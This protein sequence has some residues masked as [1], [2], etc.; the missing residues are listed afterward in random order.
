MKCIR[1]LNLKV[2]S[3][4]I[5]A[6]VSSCQPDKPIVNSPNLDLSDHTLIKNWYS[7]SLELGPK[8]NGFEEPIMARSLA[9]YS[10]L[11]HESV[12]RGIPDLKSLKGS[13]GA[14]NFNFPQP[15]L[16][17]EYNWTTVANE[18]SKVY[19]ENIYGSGTNAKQRIQ[20]I[21]QNIFN[22]F[23]KGLDSV[24]LANSK[25]YGRELAFAVLNYAAED[26]QSEAYLDVFTNSY[27]IPTG[28][29]KW[30]PTTP[31][32]S[33]RP[34]LP[35]WGKVRPIL[36]Q[37]VDVILL[38]K[39]LNYS[40]S[41]S[42]IMY[43][44]AVEIYNMA[45]AMTEQEK[46]AAAYF[47]RDMGAMSQALYH[48]YLLAIQLMAE[49]QLDFPKSLEL[50][51][52]LSFA[53]HDGNIACYKYIYTNNLLR[54]STYIRQN[55]NRIY[56]PEYKSLP[57]PEGISDK[58]VC[59]SIGAE[60]LSNFFGY[61]QSFTDNTQVERPDLRNKSKQFDSFQQFSIEATQG[62][63]YTG[64]HFRTSI[65]AGR[66]LGT[67]IARNTINFINK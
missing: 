38:N 47:N 65:D 27:T 39:E 32:Y 13:S 49:N 8:C 42:S 34:M 29:G 12:Y 25:L 16:S 7:L 33:P 52:K 24:V 63:I 20:S 10:I 54:A 1:T 58:S 55:I 46:E 22:R 35:Y 62:D 4:G 53:L 14:F 40:N 48:N 11:V 9:Y 59:Y 37:N 66:K 56:Q 26:G 57:I 50:M 23:S 31:D 15:D 30:I 44:E 45:L 2:L 28:E 41:S 36:N 6:I 60:I 3:I 5:L 51:S 21:Y 67:D 18:A 17:Y 61:R 64:I 43:S 19:F